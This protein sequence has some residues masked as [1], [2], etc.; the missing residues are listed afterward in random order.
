MRTCRDQSSRR[1]DPERLEAQVLRVRAEGQLVVEGSASDYER[2]DFLSGEVFEPLERPLERRHLQG[3]LGI[4]RRP[5]ERRR[6]RPQSPAPDRAHCIWRAHG[7]NC[8]A[9]TTRWASVACAPLRLTRA[10][11]T[12]H[13]AKL[14]VALLLT[15]GRWGASLARTSSDTG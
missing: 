2:N 13:G 11:E 9:P 6:F 10:V 5:P 8:K 12:R 7:G 14:P 1:D 4:H 15:P 3:G